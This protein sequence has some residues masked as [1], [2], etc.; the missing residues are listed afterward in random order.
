MDWSMLVPVLMLAPLSTGSGTPAPEPTPLASTYSIIAKDPQT[1][2]F[3]VAVQ[4]HYFSVGP[5]VP[6][7]ESG[8]GA[9]ATQ[10]LVLVDYGPRALELMRNGM[11]ARQALDSLLAA[12]PN[13][14][15]RQVAIID[16]LGRVAAHTGRLCIPDAGHKTGAQYSCQGNMMSKPTVWLEMAYD[17]QR[18]RGNFAERLLQALESAEKAGG[19]IR[20]RQSAALLIVKPQTTGKPW[21]DKFYDLRVEDHPEPL[22]EL[23]RLVRL[24]TAYNLEDEGDNLIAA[25][26]PDEAMK[27]YEQAMKLAPEVSELQ[28]WAA[29]SMYSNGRETEA[30]ELFRT[31]FVKEPHWVELIPRLAKVFL[32]PNDDAKVADVVSLAPRGE[33][34]K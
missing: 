20:G 29:V 31:L 28:F 22:L 10:S 27:A 8:V 1:G 17:Y 30:R 7:A 5:I 18:A 23:R 34:G 12:D 11:S 32:F 13:P 26:K 25:K 33:P 4:S 15:V 3:G 14:D 16:R 6:W 19:D 24:R 2:E 21:M 9:V